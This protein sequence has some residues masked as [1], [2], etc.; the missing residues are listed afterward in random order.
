MGSWSNGPR[1]RNGNGP[2]GLDGSQVA[3][4]I[5]TEGENRPGFADGKASRWRIGAYP[6]EIRD[7]VREMR[8][9]VGEALAPES[10]V[11][12]VPVPAR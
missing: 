5:P 2:V 4:E 10:A 7:A 6:C 1:D 3:T 8:E 12:V 11:E 9:T